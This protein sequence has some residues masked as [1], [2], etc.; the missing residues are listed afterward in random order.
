MYVG[1]VTFQLSCRNVMRYLPM[2][3]VEADAVLTVIYLF[4]YFCAC[5]QDNS[6]CY[7]WIFIKFGA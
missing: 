3:L 5:E 6:N 1:V 7:A 2:P 4:V